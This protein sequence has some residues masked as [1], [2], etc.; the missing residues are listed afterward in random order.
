MFLPCSPLPCP[1]PLPLPLPLAPALPP[2]DS[3]PSSPAPWANSEGITKGCPT[4]PTARRVRRAGGVPRGAYSPRSVSRASTTRTRREVWWRT[5]SLA[6]LGG[7]VSPLAWAF[8][9]S[10][11]RAAPP[12]TTAP[13]APP[14]P[15]STRALRGSSQMSTTLYVPPTAHRALRARRA[16]QGRG[17][18]GTWRGWGGSNRTTARQ[19]TTARRGRGRSTNSTARRAS[20]VTRWGSPLRTNARCAPPDSIVRRGGRRPTDRARRGTFRGGEK[21]RRGGERG[22]KG[23]CCSQPTVVVGSVRCAWVYDVR[24]CSM[25][26]CGMLCAVVRCARCDVCGVRWLYVLT[27]VRTYPLTPLSTVSLRFPPLS[28]SGTFAPPVLPCPRPTRVKPVR[29]IR[30]Q[31]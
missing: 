22:E 10:T 28:S 6:P 13:R 25:R 19:D 7:R 3:T 17:R 15:L 4:R 26:G 30:S 14:T 27:K 12:D 8:T 16:T 23:T 31:I 29:T 5:A 24:G 2:P 1:L 21:R 11:T 9:T 18:W 20:T